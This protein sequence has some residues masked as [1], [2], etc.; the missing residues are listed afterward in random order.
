MRRPPRSSCGTSFGFPRRISSVVPTAAI[1]FPA[2]ATASTS[3][4]AG[5]PVQ[6]FA[7]K[8]TS[9]HVVCAQTP[10]EAVKRTAINRAV[11]LGRNRSIF[12]PD[13]LNFFF[14]LESKSFTNPVLEVLNHS[15]EIGRPADAVVIDQVG[16][17]FRNL[18][19]APA[20]ALCSDL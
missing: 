11:K 13:V 18:D 3:G 17:V 14:Y 1:R 6:I 10:V 19:I 8:R 12:K 9:V 5:L 20:N 2:T 16:V 7:L 4:C 15:H